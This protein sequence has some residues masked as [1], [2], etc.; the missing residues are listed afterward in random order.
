[1]NYYGIAM[2]KGSELK[3]KIDE[4][5]KALQA[6]G[7]I[8]ALVLKWKHLRRKHRRNHRSVSGICSGTTDMREGGTPPSRFQSFPT[9]VIRPFAPHAS[10]P[11]ERDIG[12]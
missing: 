10:C 12:G 6:D 11:I 7:T 3:A 4:A 1:M 5:I 8:D 9:E 2:P